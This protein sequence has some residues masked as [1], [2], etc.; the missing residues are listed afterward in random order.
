MREVYYTT[1]AERAAAIAEA[2]AQGE[3]MLHDDFRVGPRGQNRLTFGVVPDLPPDPRAEVLKGLRAKGKAA[4]TLEDI[5]DAIG[6]LIR[7]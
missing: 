4:W 6:A 7:L 1:Q 5:K 2:Q 3:T